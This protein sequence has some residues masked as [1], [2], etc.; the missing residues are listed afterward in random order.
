M[1]Q[2][3]TLGETD[4]AHEAEGRTHMRS[5]REP[6]GEIRTDGDASVAVRS[7]KTEGARMVSRSRKLHVS[8]SV[9]HAEL[10]DEVVLLDTQSGMYFSV[11]GVGTRIWE[12][13][14]TGMTEEHI[15]QRI[16]R[17]Y[18]VEPDMARADVADFLNMLAERGLIR[19]DSE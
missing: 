10:D 1:K 5:T 11:D 16:V 4:D 9:T 7:E 12:L 14:R 3:D 19:E 2:N 18:A 13:L 6:G 8:S 17:E 15:V